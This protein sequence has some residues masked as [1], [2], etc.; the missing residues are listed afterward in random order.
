MK[1]DLFRKGVWIISTLSHRCHTSFCEIFIL[2]CT[3]EEYENCD[4]LI[5]YMTHKSDLLFINDMWSYAKKI[6]SILY[7]KWCDYRCYIKKTYLFLELER[8]GP[9]HDT[10]LG[11]IITMNIEP[12]A[13]LYARRS[14]RY[15]LS[16]DILILL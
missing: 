13:K 6:S 7:W 1:D 10:L 4:L 9:V 14:H 5:D 2:L 8:L 15:Y 12:V 16:I 11:S 3:I